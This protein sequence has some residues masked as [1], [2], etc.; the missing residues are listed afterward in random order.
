M[1]FLASLAGDRSPILFRACAGH[2]EGRSGGSLVRSS[3]PSLQVRRRPSGSV[4]MREISFGKACQREGW[5][6]THSFNG[7]RGWINFNAAPGIL[8]DPSVRTVCV[9]IHRHTGHSRRG[10]WY[11][12]GSLPYPRRIGARFVR[13]LASMAD[14]VPVRVGVS[15][16][17]LTET[18]DRNRHGNTNP[19]RGRHVKDTP[20]RR[21]A[22]GWA[23]AAGRGL[24]R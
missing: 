7:K 3:V 13:R 8:L 6:F 19:G 5:T 16:D 10:R 4:A 15:P 21:L 20:A 24:T 12:V 9:W 2:G 22:L 1:G 17:R 14:P 11:R 18:G 23:P